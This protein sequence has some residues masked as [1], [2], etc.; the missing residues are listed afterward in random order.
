MTLEFNMYLCISLLSE[1]SLSFV[2][3]NLESPRPILIE[4]IEFQ[5]ANIAFFAHILSI[6]HIFIRS[7]NI[8]SV[9]SPANLLN[10]SP[11]KSVTHHVRPP[12][13]L[14][15]PSV[16]SNIVCR[17]VIVFYSGNAYYVHIPQQNVAMQSQA[18]AVHRTL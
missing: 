10:P 11:T 6:F 9:Y 5:I 2:L 7:Y 12:L 8:Q 13:P 18:H 17:Y 1:V 3:Y 14:L 15:Y 16:K 4:L